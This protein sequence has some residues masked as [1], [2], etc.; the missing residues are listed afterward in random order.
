[1]PSCSSTASRAASVA[2]IL[3]VERT[4]VPSPATLIL[5]IGNRLLTDEGAGLHLLDYLAEHHAELPGVNFLDGGTLGFILAPQVQDCDNLI[6]LD[7]AQLDRPAG[8]VCL[9]SGAEMD[10][11]ISQG[12]LSVHEVGLA[13]LMSIARLTDRLPRNRALLGI[14]PQTLGWGENP[15]EAVAA[16]IPG[17]ARK[18]IDLLLLWGMAA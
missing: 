4:A 11:F 8:S 2:L 16:A 5:G 17:A 1:M 14:Q 18:V 3:P 15:S 9:F 7:A 10:A 12:S 6:V 13:D